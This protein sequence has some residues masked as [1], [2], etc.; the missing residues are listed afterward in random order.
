MFNGK[1][2]YNPTGKA[3]E[4]AR[5]AC[6]L[7]V[8]CSNDCDYCYCK[9]GVLGNVMGKPQATLKK[10]FR[11]QRNAF[12]VFTK[13]LEKCAGAIRKEG[14]L[15][16]SFTTDPCLP[17]TIDLTMLCLMFATEMDVPCRI[18]TKCAAWA[19]DESVMDSLRTV[20]RKVAIGFTLTGMDSME[21]GPTVAPNEERIALMQRLHLEGFRTFASIEPVIEIPSATDV[22]SKTVRDCD[23]YEIG[24][25][26][27]RKSGYDWDELNDFVKTVNFILEKQGTPVY[28]KESVRKQLNYTINASCAVEKNYDMFSKIN[29]EP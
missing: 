13:E 14:G 11:N 29:K 26:S 4:Y 27:G 23:F 22:F 19:N 21:K 15:F 24:L 12:E 10:C 2:I 6:N 8:G 5:W 17:E 7:Y 20:K 16:F 18:L 1:A 28:W 9:Q 25:Q 3:G